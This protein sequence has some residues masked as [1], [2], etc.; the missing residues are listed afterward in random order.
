MTNQPRGIRPIQRRLLNQVSD[1]L[2]ADMTK[3][4]RMDLRALAGEDLGAVLNSL[5]DELQKQIDQRRARRATKL[6]ERSAV[7]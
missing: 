7:A 2:H 6:E 3:M 5:R 4:H 1:R